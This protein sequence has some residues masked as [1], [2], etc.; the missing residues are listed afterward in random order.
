MNQQYPAI[1]IFASDEH[2]L[3]LHGNGKAYSF[4]YGNVISRKIFLIFL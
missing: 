2:S 1:D 3:V 4:G